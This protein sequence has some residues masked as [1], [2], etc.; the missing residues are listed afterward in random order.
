MITVIEIVSNE[1][2]IFQVVVIRQIIGYL[3]FMNK[4]VHFLQLLIIQP[5]IISMPGRSSHQN[6]RD[7]AGLAK[8]YDFL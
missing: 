2:W 5:V 8:G 3:D 7:R 4:V 6:Q 1:T